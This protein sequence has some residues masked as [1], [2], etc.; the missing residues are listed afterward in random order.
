MR[1]IY[2]I[3]GSII[4]SYCIIGSIFGTLAVQELGGQINTEFFSPEIKQDTKESNKVG[5]YFA[6][7]A[8][9]AAWLFPVGIP[10]AAFGFIKQ[11]NKKYYVIIGVGVLIVVSIF[12]VPAMIFYS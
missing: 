4:L 12:Y 7:L 2:T 3:I 8:I 5:Q 9:T 10:M 1:K 6:F 11:S